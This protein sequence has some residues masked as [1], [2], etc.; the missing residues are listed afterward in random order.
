MTYPFL[1]RVN[2]LSGFLL[3]ILSNK[4]RFPCAID[5]SENGNS[6]RFS[7]AA[8]RIFD[9]MGERPIDAQCGNLYVWDCP[10]PQNATDKC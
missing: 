7:Y 5:A 1:D 2:V 3:F 6:Y 10:T 9:R 8:R 4:R